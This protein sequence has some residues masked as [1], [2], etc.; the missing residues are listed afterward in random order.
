M[1]PD[2]WSDQC[3]GHLRS[4]VS[5]Q[6]ET[7]DVYV[8]LPHPVHGDALWTQQ[9]QGCGRSGDAIYAGHRLF[10]ESRDLGKELTKQWA[11]YRYG[12]F[13]EIGYAGD[14][15]YPA[16]YASEKSLN[17]VNGCS[18]KPISQTKYV[19]A[20]YIVSMYYVL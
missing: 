12:V 18:D 9:S 19:F 13:D 8:G 10:Q 14:A 16:C 17:D 5:S 2:T 3:V 11:K 1:L 20:Y 7:P 6:G 4:V 15:V